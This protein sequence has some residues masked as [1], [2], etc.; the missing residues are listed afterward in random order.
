VTSLPGWS[1]QRLRQAQNA[2]LRTVIGGAV[3][4]DSP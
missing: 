2:S 1:F 3:H 4:V